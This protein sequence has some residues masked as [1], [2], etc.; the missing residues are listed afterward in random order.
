MLRRF[1]A[2]APAAL[3]FAAAAPRLPLAPTL[4]APGAALPLPVAPLTAPS[5]SLVPTA[6]T[7]R[8][9]IRGV[10]W[11]G[12]RKRHPKAFRTAYRYEPRARRGRRQMARGQRQTSGR[13]M[14]GQ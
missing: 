7:G 11:L 5:Q 3:R 10:K 9:F 4:L 8:R 2:V 14:K 13:M 6:F 1:G 12:P